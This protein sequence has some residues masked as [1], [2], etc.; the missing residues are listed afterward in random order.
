[1]TPSQ[2]QER[3]PFIEWETLLRNYIPDD[4]AVPDKIV[5]N[6][7]S[8]FEKLNDLLQSGKV[9][10][11]TLRDYLAIRAAGNWI[12]TLDT[13][14]RTLLHE[15]DSK[16]ISGAS[17]L[18]PRKQ[19]CISNANDA[20]GHLVAR[21]FT[22]TKFGG[23]K[24]QDAVEEMIRLVH[25][26]WLNRLADIDWLDSETKEAAIN[27]V[28][29]ECAYGNHTNRILSYLPGFA[30]IQVNKI[31][32]KV[33]YSTISPNEQSPES[34]DAYYATMSMT[35]SFFENE[36]SVLKWSRNKTWNRIGQPVDKD[37]WDMMAQEVNAYYS[38][39]NNEASLNGK[40]S[41][42]RVS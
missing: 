38:L 35:D 15:V 5:V 34:L 1:M 8:Y 19:E 10:M 24:E 17:E 25:E 3:Y 14:T 16:I 21:Y 6:A 27:K 18:K 33:A 20:L 41:L 30:D 4:R 37:E 7:P 36:M 9:T 40:A 22:I 39:T 26:T 32:H 12:Y 29:K 11:G 28:K 31:K 2:L 42:R 23:R 13:H